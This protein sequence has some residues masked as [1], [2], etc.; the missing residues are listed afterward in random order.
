VHELP[1]RPDEATTR[2]ATPG[3]SGASLGQRIYAGGQTVD[4]S[5][6]QAGATATSEA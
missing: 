6:L 4:L 3:G 5:L 2:A 1:R